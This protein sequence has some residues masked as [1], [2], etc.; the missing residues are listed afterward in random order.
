[1][2]RRVPNPQQQP[3]FTPPT[4]WTM[5]TEFP[6][7]SAAR[8]LAIDLET[9]DP[10]LR[11]LGSGWARK[12][13]HIIGV[14]VSTE[15]QD[16]YFPIRHERGPNLDPRM[17]LRWLQDQVRVP[18]DYV[19]H[20]APY[21]LGW[22]LAEGVEVGGRVID[23]MVAAALLD[24]HR[25]SYSLDSLGEDYVGRTKQEEK[26][27]EAAAA[28]GVDPKSQMYLIPA[29][30]VGHYAEQ[31]SRLTYDLWQCL[32]PLLEEQDLNQILELELDVTRAVVPMRMRGI[33]VDLARAELT[34]QQ[35][36]VKKRDILQRLHRETGVWV[37]EWAA[38]S[39]A[40]AF[41]AAGLTYRR[42]PN[43]GAP[44]FTKHF[45]N[46]HHHPIARLIV[47]ARRY[48]K[49][50]QFVDSLFRYE[51]NGR[52]HTEL[53]QLRSDEGGTITGRF[54]SSNPNLQQIPARDPEIGPMIR[55][56]YLPEEDALWG[57]F[58][59]SSQEPRL[60]VHYAHRMRLPGAEAFRAQYLEDRRS[61]FHQLAADIVGVPRKQAK[62]INLGLFYGMGKAKL[63]MSLG[64]DEVEAEKLFAIY[65]SRVP[66]VKALSDAACRQAEAR[67]HI[68][69]LLGRR[70]RYETW[71]P[72]GYGRQARALPRPQA[73]EEYGPAI[74][75][76]FTHKALNALIQ[77]SAADQTK[78]ALVALHKEGLMPMLQIHDEIALSVYTAAEG[79][80]VVEIMENCVQ[81]EIP[82][83][84]DAELGPSWGEATQPLEDKLFPVGG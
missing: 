6:D 71:E 25:Y 29:T 35:I 5:P 75:R 42:T 67:G 84:V 39:V 63:A 37:E 50:T 79:R 10:N 41:D 13:G 16:W 23:T 31:D 19:M 15:D 54:S 56:L 77:G 51:H 21:D 58:D 40:K 70:C 36:L 2:R 59:Y 46:N 49:A 78:A 65:H 12:D 32:R 18:R 30:H 76:A 68:R 52:V 14:A 74:R 43:T 9:K 66:F 82:S 24:E 33:R 55:S 1:M 7:L 45:L 47:E 26:L 80:R 28:F 8:T 44:S 60:V 64:L 38:E 34:K 73:L 62:D 22:L 17:T 57:A 83:V 53:H 61:D 11:T 69:T 27:R 72:A 48:D 20:N 4:S 81:L 3:L